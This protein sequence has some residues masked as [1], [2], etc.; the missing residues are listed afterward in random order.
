[1]LGANANGEINPQSINLT[2]EEFW[3]NNEYALIEEIGHNFLKKNNKYRTIVFGGNNPIFIP[4]HTDEKLY[5][6]MYVNNNLDS[7]D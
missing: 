3:L 7:L 2:E 4:G 1:V 5:D 6:E